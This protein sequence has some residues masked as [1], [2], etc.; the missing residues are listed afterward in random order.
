MI[1]KNST[2]LQ[3]ASRPSPI[4]IGTQ[5]NINELD[6][7]KPVYTFHSWVV[8]VHPHKLKN[9]TL[10]SSKINSLI[11]ALNYLSLKISAVT[12]RPTVFE[13]K[14]YTWYFDFSSAQVLGSL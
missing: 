1:T 7:Y 5:Y 10:K 12:F 11:K 4:H 13:M 9:C 6:V 2:N 14:S 3:A 8:H